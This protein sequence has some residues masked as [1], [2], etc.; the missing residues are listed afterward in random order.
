MKLNRRQLLIAGGVVGAGAYINYRGLRYPRL[1]FEPS[2]IARYKNYLDAEIRVK[3]LIFLNHDEVGQ[4]NLRAYSPTSRVSLTPHKSDLVVTVNNIDAKASLH[5]EGSTSALVEEE[6]NGITRKLSIRNAE[7]REMIL[8]WPLDETGPIKFAVIGDTGGGD[9]LTWCIERVHQLGAAFMLHLGDFNYSPGEYDLAID[10]FYQSPMP[11]YVSIGN[12]DFNDSGLVYE[13]FRQ[14][15]G[16]MNNTFT[17][18][19]TRFVNLDSAANFFPPY[20]GNRGALV[21][22]LKKANK[23]YSDQL[24]FTHKPFVDTRPG[25]DHNL[26][27]MGEIDWLAST[28]QELGVNNMACGHVHRS[29]EIDFFGIKQWTAGEGLGYEDFRNKK[30]T[31]EILIGEAQAGEKIKFHWQPL[32]MPWKFHTSP[33]HAFKLA[34][35]GLTEWHQS[36]MRGLVE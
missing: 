6:I 3:D 36:L 8:S 7:A 15:I 9:E 20:A 13:N 2:P 33:T 26:S 34:R 18:A 12:H 1:G 21:S 29:S 24:L 17:I 27:G 5:V 19:N 16:P 23:D 32:L 25:K 4:I 28:M 35:D 11:I 10:K 14:C 22:R 30:Q 31:A